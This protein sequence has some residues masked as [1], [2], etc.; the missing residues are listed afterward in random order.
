MNLCASSVCEQANCRICTSCEDPG[1][2]GMKCTIKHTLK[3][4]H[5]MTPQDLHW[6][7][8]RVGHQILQAHLY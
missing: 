4:I 1:L 2:R 3:L 5:F 7:N 6:H 8:E